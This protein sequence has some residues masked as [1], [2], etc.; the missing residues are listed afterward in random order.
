[1]AAATTDKFQKTGASTVTTLSA[2]GKAMGAS[3]ITVGSTTNYP[4]TTGITIAIRVVDSDGELVAGTYT[5]WLATVSSGTT[6]ALDTTP[7]YGSDQVYAAGSTTQVFM[8][9]SSASH[10][11]LIDGELVHADQD[12][13]LKAGA[14]DV[15]AVL[16]DGI[17]TE[18]KIADNWVHGSDG[19]IDSTQ[20]WTYVSAT[21]FKITGTDVTAQFPV[22]TKIKLTQTTAK[23]FYVTAATFSTDTTVTVN[24]GSDY[25]L[26]NAAITSP[27][28]SYMETPQ[29]HPGWFAYTPTVTAVSGSFTT[30]SATGRFSM[31]GRLVTITPIITITT[32]GTGTGCLFTVPVTAKA[33]GYYA[34]SGRD[35]A[36]SGKQLQG[37]LT[38]TTQISMANYDNTNPSASGAVFRIAGQYEAA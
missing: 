26:A 17:I 21:S 11:L 22:G 34:V 1:M 15:T 18:A 38:S 19:W 36:V 30:T 14:V 4:D 6:L 3:S 37:R 23:Y 29:G 32:V 33:S 35:D 10:N 16:A 9:V 28:Y 8:P 13:T 5:E 27:M 24:G 31:N 12:G 20:T 7:V 25:T 2:P